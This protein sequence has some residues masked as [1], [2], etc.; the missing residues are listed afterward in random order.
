[1]LLINKNQSS[2]DSC[3]NNKMLSI[4]PKT[5]I[6]SYNIKANLSNGNI[7][8]IDNTKDLNNIIEYIISKGYNIVPLSELIIE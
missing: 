6:N 7:F 4:L 3:I 1:M 2:L 8:L 5:N